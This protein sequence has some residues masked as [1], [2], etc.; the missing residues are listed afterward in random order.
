MFF[1]K[2]VVKNVQFQH[3]MIPGKNFLGALVNVLKCPWKPVPPNLLMLP[4]PLHITKSTILYIR[5]YICS[6][7]MH[8]SINL[9]PTFP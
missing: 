2:N 8:D 3:G 6:V 7:E 4:T 9:S 5:L 1:K